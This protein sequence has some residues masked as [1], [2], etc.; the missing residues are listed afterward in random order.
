MIVLCA[1]GGGAQM[2][3]AEQRCNS[4][5]GET[6]APSTTYLHSQW[7]W[8][9]RCLRLRVPGVETRRA[10]VMAATARHS[11]ARKCMAKGN[12]QLESE[13]VQDLESRVQV[14]VTGW[15]RKRGIVSNDLGTWGMDGVQYSLISNGCE[16]VG[17]SGSAPIE[18]GPAC[19]CQT[20]VVVTCKVRATGDAS[21]SQFPLLTRVQS[22]D[23]KS[24]TLRP[25]PA[26]LRQHATPSMTQS[27]KW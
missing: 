10:F 4:A 5:S 26:A 13:A 20:S 21:S 22:P 24:L 1:V 11:V 14:S 15:P 27:M 3:K 12:V 19:A 8:P 6:T 16:N 7:P 23:G 18:F 2:R 9:W 25:G 17:K